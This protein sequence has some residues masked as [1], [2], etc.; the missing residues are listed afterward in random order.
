MGDHIRLTTDQSVIA[1]PGG[2]VHNQEEGEHNQVE[3]TQPRERKASN[4][5]YTTK[6]KENNL[7]K[8]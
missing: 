2:K 1:Q 6:R 8:G 5:H 7:V 3:G 4:C